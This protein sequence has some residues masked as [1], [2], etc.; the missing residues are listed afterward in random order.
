MTERMDTRTPHCYG[1]SGPA[2]TQRQEFSELE[3]LR[4]ALDQVGYGLVAVDV[5]TAAIQFTNALGRDALHEEHAGDHALGCEAGLR[6]A[7]GRVAT[8]D[9][10]AAHLLLRTLARARS[11]MRS[12]LSLGEDGKNAV[13]VVPLSAT[14]HTQNAA[15]PASSTSGA[16]TSLA[17]LVFAKQNLCDDST[18][19][20][21]A[22]ERGL[23]SAEGQVLTQVCRGLRPAQIA[24]HH[25]VQ[26]STVRTQLRSIRMKT[27]CETIRELVQK[28][29]VLPPMAL[30]LSSR[31][32]AM[33]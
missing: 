19:A 13:A 2:T 28:V 10:L 26:I 8:R 32:L 30:H 23:T 29:S 4:M 14:R 9:P 20:L 12:L 27:C 16:P 25:G 17:L 18:V 22:R 24:D 31:S 33:A 11:G 21:F 15:L 5:D 1:V 7:H 3:L 6:E